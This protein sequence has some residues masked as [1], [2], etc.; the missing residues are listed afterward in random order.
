M[1]NN[2]IKY[3]KLHWKCEIRMIQQSL[4]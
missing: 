4:T 3:W 1:E 2:H